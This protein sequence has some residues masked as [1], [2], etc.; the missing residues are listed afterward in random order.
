MLC[1]QASPPP[2]MRSD[3]ALRVKSLG[4]VVLK[5]RD[6]ERAEAFYS[7]VLGIPVISRISDPIRMTFFTLGRHHDFAVIEVGAEAPS[8]APR[9]VG[10]AHVAFEIGDSQEDFASARSHLDAAGITILYTAERA[11]TTSIHLH[12][13]DGNE[14]ELYVENADRATAA[15]PLRAVD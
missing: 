14:V 1:S 13:P 9:A 5:V 12:D 15:A 8:P 3:T 2:A 6:I 11:F 7:G 10:L 4:H